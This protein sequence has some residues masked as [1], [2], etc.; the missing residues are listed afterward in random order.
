[1]G[2]N[3]INF[4]NDILLP[5]ACRNCL[6][7]IADSFEDGSNRKIERNQKVQAY[8]IRTLLGGNLLQV[9]CRC[10]LQYIAT[11]YKLGYLPQECP[12]W[13]CQS[14]Q[15]QNG[16][17]SENWEPH[18]KFWWWTLLTIILYYLFIYNMFNVISLRY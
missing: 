3:L 18:L 12:W 9:Q 1:M 11:D 8:P 4:S 6:P 7:V 13:V 5:S 2:C 17:K 10:W 14:Q 15:E 16:W